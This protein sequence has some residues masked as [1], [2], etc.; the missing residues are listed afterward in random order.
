M[1][2]EGVGDARAIWLEVPWAVRRRRQQDKGLLVLGVYAPQVGHPTEERR[3][4]WRQRC[5]EY[6]KLKNRSRYQGWDVMVTGDFNIHWSYLCEANRRYERLLDREVLEMIRGRSGFG[7]MVGNPVGKGTHASGTAIDIAAASCNISV[8]VAKDPIAGL[9]SD[10]VRLDISVQGGVQAGAD[11][12]G[13]SMWRRSG[14]GG[15]DAAL[16]AIPRS[17]EFITAFA[18]TAMRCDSIKG[19]VAAGTKRGTRQALL[20]K[21]VWWREVCYTLCGH[22]GGMVVTRG[23]RARSHG[24]TR[25]DELSAAIQP[26]G[27]QLTDEALEVA[28]LIREECGQGWMESKKSSYIDTYLELAAENQG[29][30]EAYLSGLVKPRKGVQVALVGDKGECL[31][32]SETL[33]FLTQDVLQRGARAPSG[34]PVFSKAVG[35]EVK[36]CRRSAMAETIAEGFENFS[37]KQVHEVLDH[38]VANRRSMRLPR[39][40]VKAKLAIARQLVWALVNLAMVFGLVAS[41]WAREISPLRK[42]GPEV[43]SDPI[44]LRPVGYM[45]D[46]AGVFDALWLASVKEALDSYSGPLQAGG[47]HDAVLMV[48]GILMVL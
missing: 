40:A 48:L 1:Q 42:A 4:F 43:V 20:D 25:L 14:D 9:T 46:L 15:W 10:H 31:G 12:I 29:S 16:A 18:V 8:E 26:Q 36:D 47:K 13:R 41:T 3:R 34:D 23:P 2:I 45:S 32:A 21:V 7:C 24:S 30:A 28:R 27:C 37:I 39:G 19:W 44:N 5:E 22:F 35:M 11:T 33:E 17:L 38:M 6:A